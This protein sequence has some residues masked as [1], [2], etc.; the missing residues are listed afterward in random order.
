VTLSVRRRLAMIG[1]VL[2]VSI[3][4]CGNQRESTPSASTCQAIVD[5]AVAA[6]E[7]SDQ[8]SLLDRALVVCRSSTALSA[9][10]EQ[11]PG[12]FGVTAA[13]FA[14]ARCQ[15][16]PSERISQ[17]SICRELS[18]PNTTQ[19]VLL[20]SEIQTYLA[21]TLDGREVVLTSDRVRFA[22]GRPAVVVQLTDIMTEDGCLAVEAEYRGWVDEVLDPE[23]GDEASVYA[24]HALNLL[25][26]F[27]CPPIS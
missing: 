9:A 10:L 6:R 1:L 20:D 12:A 2:A 21:V 26:F 15:A 4:G 16:P 13:E 19:P 17:S 25:R 3:A 18:P 8:L 11:H 24:Q 7:I 27:G 14:T 22:E 23:R 5:D